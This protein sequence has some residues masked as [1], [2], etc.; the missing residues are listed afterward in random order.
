M[1]P[2]SLVMSVG[3]FVLRAIDQCPGFSYGSGIDVAH[4][5]LI[6]LS[7]SVIVVFWGLFDRK[8]TRR[9]NSNFECDV[10]CRNYSMTL[11]Y[12]YHT[13][14]LFISVSSL[15]NATIP[16][17]IFTRRLLPEAKIL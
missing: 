14:V 5:F 7:P 13:V 4:C 3:N 16:C 15:Y 10:L 12:S 11:S 17:S 6:T 2:C 8:E 9:V 1:Q